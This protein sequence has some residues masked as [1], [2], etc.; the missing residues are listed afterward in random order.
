MR[1]HLISVILALGILASYDSIAGGLWIN[2]FGSPIMG[3]AGAGSTSGVDDASAALHNPASMT[4]LES[5]QIMVTA[6]VVVSE[7]EFDIDSSE[8][9]NGSN[10]GGDAGDVAPIASLF[11]VRDLADSWKLGVYAGGFTGAALEYDDDWVG[12]FQ[13][14]RVELVALG[15]MPSLAYQVS[16]RFSV[17]IGVPVLYGSLEIDVALPGSRV[18]DAQAELDGDDTQVGLNLSAFYVVSDKTR[19]GL[20]YQ[21]A[22]DFK[23]GGDVDIKNFPASGTLAIDTELTLAEY[24]KGSVSHDFTDSFSGH[25]TVGWEGWSDMDSVLI[26]GENNQI[27]LDQDWGDIW[28]YALGIEYQ[29]APAWTMNAGIR[30]DE[31]P[32][33]AR[34]RTADM[35]MDEQT[36]YALGIKYQRREGLTIGAHMVYADYGDADII[37]EN[38]ITVPAPGPL[39]GAIEIP[40]GFS[41]S[42]KSN[43]LLFF[44]VSF[45]WCLGN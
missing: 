3:R 45:N 8:A 31:N 23:Y 25:I 18:N 7:I 32:T 13:A 14:Q 2:E 39:P 30:Y 11:Y 42:Y 33:E 36:R 29:L 12:R 26:S 16:E 37:A 9:V 24:L 17:G 6:G 40:T 21:S 20:L 27:A 4:A 5:D 28:H 41:G 38:T 44:M 22:F 1:R 15:V 35:P 43:D 34:K 19:V 10:N